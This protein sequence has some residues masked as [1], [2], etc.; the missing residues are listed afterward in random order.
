MELRF[1]DIHDRAYLA[2][3]NLRADV[4]RKPLGLPAGAE[5][6]PFE[7]TALHLIALEDNEVVGCVMFKPEARTGRMLQMAIRE[8]RQKSGI[9]T[10]LV[11]HL[12]KRLRGEG[13]TDIYCHARDV[14]VP[15]YER[16]GYAVEGE[17]F[18]EVGIRHFL[19]RKSPL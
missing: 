4:L 3:R 12:E 16:L 8:D 11:K 19:M 1:I 18:T 17:P 6:F 5:V 13:Y 2:E 10:M 7:D 9:G 15:F 14:A